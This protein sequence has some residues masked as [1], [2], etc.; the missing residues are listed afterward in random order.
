MTRRNCFALAITG[1]LT[2][3]T[4]AVTLDAIQNATDS[5]DSVRDEHSSP[6]RGVHALFDVD[7][8][9]IGPFPRTPLRSASL[10]TTP[11]AG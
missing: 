2:L 10:R 7:R 9:D 3:T 11:D 5:G 8:P 4:P 1:A 6:A